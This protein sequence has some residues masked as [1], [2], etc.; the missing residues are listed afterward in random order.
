MCAAGARMRVSTNTKS[1]ARS[2]DDEGRLFYNSCGLHFSF[3]SVLRS[4]F[5]NRVFSYTREEFKSW[6]NGLLYSCVT[7]LRLMTGP[8]ILWEIVPCKRF[9]IRVRR[10]YRVSKNI[11]GGSGYFVT[12]MSC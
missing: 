1:A 11:F 4:T 10:T 5:W 6:A 9:I 7:S 2:H 8:F 12:L 3:L